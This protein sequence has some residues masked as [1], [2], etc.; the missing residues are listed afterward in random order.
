MQGNIQLPIEGTRK[1]QRFEKPNFAVTNPEK[2]PGASKNSLAV[3]IKKT[4]RYSVLEKE[5]EYALAKR[6]CE[7]EDRNAAQKLTAS[8][9]R[10]VVRMAMS[11]KYSGLPIEDIISEGNLGLIKAV[12]RFDP[13]RGVRLSTCARWWIRASILEYVM[14]SWSLVKVVSTA[15]QKKLFYNLRKIKAKIQAYDD[16]DLHP[17]DVSHIS[18]MLG[19]PE[20]DTIIMNRRL[21]RDCSLNVQIKNDIDIGEWQDFLVNDD[22]NQEDRLGETQELNRRRKIL[23]RAMTLLDDRERRI[24]ISRRLSDNT[25]TLR[26]LSHEF[27]VSYERIRQIE[28]RAFEKIQESVVAA[29]SAS[30]TEYLN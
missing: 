16:G 21:V 13:Y 29:E 30:E 17:D 24:F 22:I 15:N 7:Q 14:R 10:L 28:V 12:E 8:H 2:S 1:E 27:G 23:E 19:V 25:R 11:F 20:A 18:N 6:W 9:L 4:S 3:Y 26:E 5:E